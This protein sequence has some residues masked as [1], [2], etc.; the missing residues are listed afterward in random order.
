MAHTPEKWEYVSEVTYWNDYP[1]MKAHRVKM[2]GGT[3]TVGTHEPGWR[4]EPELEAKARLIAAAPDLLEAV[5]TLLWAV[6]HYTRQN[7][8][9]RE[10]YEFDEEDVRAARAA[11]AKAKGK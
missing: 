2:A 5:E 8:A 10:G 3:L 4:G 7:D 6:E 11:I 9:D 1:H